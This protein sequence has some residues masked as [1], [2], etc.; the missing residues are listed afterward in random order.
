MLVS[1]IITKSQLL[2]NYGYSSSL[3]PGHTTIEE[4]ENAALFILL[5]LPSTLNRHDNRAFPNP[6]QT[7]GIWKP[8]LFV[9]VWTDDILKT[10]RFENDDS[11]DFPAGVFSNTNPK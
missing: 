10:E 2:F 4:F 8:K 5:N 7:E 9:Y 3:G 6:L 1:V 11:G